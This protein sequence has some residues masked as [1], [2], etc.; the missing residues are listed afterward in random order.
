MEYEFKKIEVSSIK[1][2]LVLFKL[3]YPGETKFTEEYLHWLYFQNPF[4]NVIGYNAY[5]DDEVIA[6][7]AVIPIIDANGELCVLSLNTATSSEHTGKGLFTKLAKRTYQLVEK[8][9]YSKIIGIA[10]Q[11]SIYGFVNKLDFTQLGHVNLSIIIRSMLHESLIK[12]FIVGIDSLWKLKN[13]SVQYYVSERFG[14][15]IIFTKKKGFYVILAAVSQELNIDIPLKKIPFPIMCFLPYF[16]HSS[17]NVGIRIS[18]KL[19][20]SPWH[21]ISRS[22]NSVDSDVKLFGIHMDTF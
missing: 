3:V 13:P 20:P 7:Y 5:D 15:Q 16:N 21:V 14:Y 8:A 17:Y 1:K 12:N 9:N 11:N 6:H 10:N 2:V 22:A 19:L 18:N 4:G